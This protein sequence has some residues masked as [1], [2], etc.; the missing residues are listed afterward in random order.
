MIAVFWLRFGTPTDAYRS[1]TEEEIQLIASQKKQI[2]LYF[3]DFPIPPSKTINPEFK[4]QY[5]EV[6]DFKRN[7]NGLYAEITSKEIF[8]EKLVHDLHLYFLGIIEKSTLLVPTAGYDNDSL[9]KIETNPLVNPITLIRYDNSDEAI[10]YPIK[11]NTITSIAEYTKARVAIYRT[12]QSKK[13]VVI[14]ELMPIFS[15]D[16]DLWKIVISDNKFEKTFLNKLGI[17]RIPSFRKLLLS[18]DNE[19]YKNIDFN[20]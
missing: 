7:C 16:S 1:G 18:L 14:N 4:E 10:I 12:H 13:D 19:F 20:Y 8:Q 11:L 6:V 2:F 3:L 17:R 9:S 15:H 5:N